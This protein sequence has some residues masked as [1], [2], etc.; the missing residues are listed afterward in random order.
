MRSRG[1]RDAAGMR[2]FEPP[3]LSR[4]RS[5]NNSECLPRS[6]DTQTDAIDAPGIHSSVL[7]GRSV[8]ECFVSMGDHGGLNRVVCSGVVSSSAFVILNCLLF[9]GW[10][11]IKRQ[12]PPYTPRDPLMLRLLRLR[13][14]S[15]H[16]PGGVN[17]PCC[18]QWVP[19]RWSGMDLPA[20]APLGPLQVSD[21]CGARWTS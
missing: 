14:R 5:K 1:A 9:P 10:D 17:F 21:R 8:G 7:V 12:Q 13:L 3:M 18:G 16:A 6:G 19:Q 4:T 2:R 11:S 15:G 20:C